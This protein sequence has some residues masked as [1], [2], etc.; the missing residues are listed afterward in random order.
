MNDQYND[1][2]CNASLKNELI[3][4]LPAQGMSRAK[5][6]LPFLPFSRTTLHQWSHDGRFPASIRLS[7]TV[8]AWQNSEVLAWIESHS[9]SSND[10]E[11]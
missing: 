4:T 2:D 9:K 10:K 6:I 5:T 3:S 7:P 8:V 11:A 1:S